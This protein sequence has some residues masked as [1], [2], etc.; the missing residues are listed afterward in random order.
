ME[1]WTL[2]FSL[3]VT[4]LPVCLK[5]L[6][7]SHCQPLVPGVVTSFES[8]ISINYGSQGEIRRS[9]VDLAVPE[10]IALFDALIEVLSALLS[11]GLLVQVCSGALVMVGVRK[12]RV[13]YVT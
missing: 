11:R 2:A 7:M 5:L 10:K 12:P 4:T 8:P 1:A 9:F 6:R 3:A 13:S